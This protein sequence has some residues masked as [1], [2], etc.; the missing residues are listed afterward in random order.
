M[1]KVFDYHYLNPIAEVT[2]TEA[3][4]PHWRQK[5]VTYFVTF[6]L[7]D[8]LPQSKLN[9]L[10]IERENWLLNNPKPYDL[11]QREE[12]Y[13]LFSVR[14][15]KWLDAGEGKCFLR[16][17][18]CRRFV[19]EALIHFAGSRYDLGKYVT[20][21][22]HVHVLVSPYE[23]HSLSSI[24]HSWKSYSA[25]YINHTLGRSG[26]LWQKEY[27]DHIVRSAHA[28]YQI[29]KYIQNHAEYIP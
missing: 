29:E 7:V 22:N 8:S 1:I 13:D 4:L 11:R 19:E 17:P 5:G 15:E 28:A 12:F 2:K 3:N 6:R 16:E 24:V 27:Y 23:D 14:L 10:K 9:R 25:N 18:A 20:A 26:V 21:S